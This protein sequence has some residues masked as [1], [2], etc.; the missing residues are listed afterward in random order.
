MTPMEDLMF[1]EQPTTFTEFPSTPMEDLTFVEQPTTFTEFPPTPMGPSPTPS[2]QPATGPTPTP[3]E[4]PATPM[5]HPTT[6]REGPAANH[7]YNGMSSRVYPQHYSEWSVMDDPYW[8]SYATGIQNCSTSMQGASTYPISNVDFNYYSCAP[9]FQIELTNDPGVA[10]NLEASLRSS[11][12]PTDAEQRF[13]ISL[14]SSLRQSQLTDLERV[15]ISLESS[16]FQSDEADGVDAIR[17]MVHPLSGERIADG[18]RYNPD[19]NVVDLGDAT[20]IMLRN[21]PNRYTREMLLAEFHMNEVL[22]S[23]DFFYLPIDLRFRRNVGYCFLNLVSC[24]A[25]H[26]FASIFDNAKLT[27][28]PNSKSCL[29]SRAKIQGKDANIEQYRNSAV[30]TMHEKFHPI[31]FE[32]GQRISFP[33]PTKSKAELRAQQSEKTSVSTRVSKRS[34]YSLH[35]ESK[36]LY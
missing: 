29:I 6:P 35:S 30:I 2:E 32:N 10:I 5:E 14:E 7:V 34:D 16:L 1:V 31:L 15:S 21:I 18:P 23:I 26:E 27:Q 12:M 9:D 20:T 24:D 8:I 22:E 33:P 19:V 11:E 25:V 13:S 4:E 28:V 17:K 3:S 36:Y